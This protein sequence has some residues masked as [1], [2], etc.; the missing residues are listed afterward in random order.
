VPSPMLRGPP[1]RRWSAAGPTGPAGLLELPSGWFHGAVLPDLSGQ[2]PVFHLELDPVPDAHAPGEVVA[3][4]PG[5]AVV[6]ELDLVELVEHQVVALAGS[7]I[8]AEA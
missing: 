2:D 3:V 5:N 7:R 4:A 1:L 8:G 6:Q